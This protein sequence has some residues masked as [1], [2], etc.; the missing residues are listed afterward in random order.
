MRKELK[1]FF[2]FRSDLNY[3]VNSEQIQLSNFLWRLKDSWM[4]LKCFRVFK[5]CEAGLYLCKVSGLDHFHIV[6]SDWWEHG[7]IQLIL[8]T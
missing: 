5:H 8:Q 6:G 4:Y 1:N 2:G 7:L 3:V